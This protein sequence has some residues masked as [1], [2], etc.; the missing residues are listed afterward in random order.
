MQPVEGVGRHGALFSHQIS[1]FDAGGADDE[2]VLRR[3]AGE[4]AGRDEE[5]AALAQ[6]PFATA[7]RGFDQ[8]RLEKVVVN[9]AEAR[10]PRVFKGLI[11]VNASIRHDG[12]TCRF[13]V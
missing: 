13:P 9:G 3:A 4:F 2:L 12:C 10:H 7:Q 8:G 11:G 6:P 5:R 1:F